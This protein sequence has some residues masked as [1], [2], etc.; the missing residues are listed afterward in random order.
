MA[1]LSPTTLVTGLEHVEQVIKQFFS[2]KSDHYSLQ[3]IL[4]KGEEHL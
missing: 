1:L 3:N 4:L 2:G